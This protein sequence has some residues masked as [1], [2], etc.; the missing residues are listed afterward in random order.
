MEEADWTRTI[1]LLTRRDTT[2][3]Q[4]AYKMGPKKIMSRCADWALLT[5]KRM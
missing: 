3:T 2:K 4:A 5:I 1:S